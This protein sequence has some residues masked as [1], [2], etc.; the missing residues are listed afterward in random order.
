MIAREAFRI[1]LAV[2]REGENHM[3]KDDRSKNRKQE[4][5]HVLIMA[6]STFPWA[7][8]VKFGDEV[9]KATIM[10]KTK[11]FFKDFPQKP[12]TDESGSTSADGNTGTLPDISSGSSQVGNEESRKK[13]GKDQLE[14]ELKEICT[15]YYQLEPISWFI[16]KELKDFVTDVILL[17][18]RE[19]SRDIRNPV[20]P[21]PK[22]SMRENGTDTSAA[23]KN[24]I[25][26]KNKRTSWTAAAYFRAWLYDFWGNNIHI[27]EIDIDE[28]N[29]ADALKPVMDKIRKLYDE[30]ENKDTWRL[31]MDTHGGFRDISM[32]LISAARFFATDRT[33][34]IKTNGIFSVYHS[35]KSEVDDQIINQTA[36]YFTE[37]AEALR[38]FLVYGQYLSLQFLPYTGREKHAFIS[39]RHDRDFLTSVRNL[40]TQFKN[41]GLL[42]WYDDGIRY[43]SDWKKTLEEQNLYADA[44][45]ALLTN[46]YFESKECWKEL[47]RAVAARKKKVSGIQHSGTSGREAEVSASTGKENLSSKTIGTDIFDTI[48][49][50]ML[51]KNVN[52]PGLL[53]VRLGSAEDTKEVTDLQ[54][55]LGVTDE[56][57]RECLGIG[58]KNCNVQWFQWFG[59]MERDETVR[60]KST[61]DLDGQIKEALE[62]IKQSMAVGVTNV[63]ASTSLQRN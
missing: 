6:L 32:V 12:I 44:F 10:K 2:A 21:A 59:Y 33:D 11:Y 55:G 43:R 23:M 38:N 15:G 57:L 37:S 22:A 9:R 13:S 17:E 25:S 40:F 62:Q 54:A 34:P 48:H 3:V 56:D 39:Y 46:S 14:Y 24:G 61:S 49:F 36:F 51:E 7:N 47:I 28:L 50:F 41:N 45:I 52:L 4:G 5:K 29:P 35:Q 60:P 26:H 20:F 58:I 27:H 42:F 8:E 63:Q 19:T 1:E 53:P 16:R 31:W 30:T 18:T